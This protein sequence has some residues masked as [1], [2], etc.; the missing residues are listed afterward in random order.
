MNKIAAVPVVELSVNLHIPASVLARVPEKLRLVREA[1]RVFF[2]GGLAHPQ[3]NDPAFATLV[4]AIEDAGDIVDRI[5]KTA[6]ALD[7]E[8]G[9]FVFS[10][11]KAEILRAANS[12]R[13]VLESIDSI[14]GNFRDY[15]AFKETFA[16]AATVCAVVNALDACREEIG[17]ALCAYGY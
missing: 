4:R 16:D 8:V 1:L 5:I 15:P 12:A 3:E 10:R 2:K 6:A 7:C 17:A 13:Q 11:Q 14:C 9:R